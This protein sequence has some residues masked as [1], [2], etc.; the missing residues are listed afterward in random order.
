MSRLIR[1][2]GA[3]LVVALASCGGESSSPGP[4]DVGLADSATDT[5]EAADTSTDALGDVGGGD[6]IP[7]T[8]GATPLPFTFERVDWEPR[9]DCLAPSVCLARDSTGPIYNVAQ[10]DEAHRLGC[11][12]VSPLGTE[13]AP[14]RCAG[15][16]GPFTTLRIAHEC[17]PMMEIGDSEFC[18]HVIAEDLWFDLEFISF[19]GGAD[20]GAFS[21]RRTLRGG[22]PC[23]VGADCESVEG[24]VRCSCPP[25]TSGDPESFCL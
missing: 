23:G 13:W 17:L 11:D 4:S 20:G 3:A 19:N 14:G 7:G 25:G 18:V 9:E 6:V 16:A 22:D 8:C 1:T 5:I 21:Y 24:G 15:N 12:S 2:G 10:E